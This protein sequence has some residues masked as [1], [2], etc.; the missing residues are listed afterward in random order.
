LEKDYGIKH[1]QKE[2]VNRCLLC[3]SLEGG[4]V[5]V[6]R[7]PRKLLKIMN[8]GMKKGEG[9]RHR[10][11]WNDRV[12]LRKRKKP[13]EKRGAGGGKK[14][15]VLRQEKKEMKKKG[16]SET[17]LPSERESEGRGGKDKIKMDG[18]AGKEEKSGY[19]KIL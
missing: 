3:C 5:W 13:H 15:E 16:R 12:Y 7:R 10:K 8:D 11:G 9:T 6:Y 4:L 14:K 1:V 18:R 2:Q 19:G 17:F